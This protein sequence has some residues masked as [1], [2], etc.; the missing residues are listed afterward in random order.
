MDD[1]DDDD[2]A[3][4]ER[5]DDGAE[6]ASYVPALCLG[7]MFAIFVSPNGFTKP[8]TK[9]R[10]Y[11]DYDDDVSP[12]SSSYSSSSIPPPP[13]SSSSLLF[14]QYYDRQHSCNTNTN[15]NTN[16]KTTKGVV[17][18]H[19]SPNKRTAFACAAAASASEESAWKSEGKKVCPI[20]QNTGLKPCGQ[21]EGTGVNQEDKYGGK[22][23]YK[24]GQPCWLCQGKRKT[25]CGN[26]IDFTDSF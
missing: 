23:G 11:D 24:K 25:M 18:T 22:D 1:G 6:N 14:S 4:T 13:K 8:L 21:C 17:E 10:D 26:C 20:C 5:R 2:D 15:T 12:S 7:K 19:F 9:R 16:A 3:R